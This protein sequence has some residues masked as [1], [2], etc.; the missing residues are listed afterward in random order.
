MRYLLQFFG[1]IIFVTALFS[2][3]SIHELKKNKYPL[4][5]SHFK[6][7]MPD[8]LQDFVKVYFQSKKIE[9]LSF[10][11]Y[12]NEYGNQLTALM[13]DWVNSGKV[14]NMTSSKAEE[15]KNSIK[16]VSNVLALKVYSDTS[17]QSLFLIDSIHWFVNLLPSKDTSPVFQRFIPRNNIKNNPFLVLKDFTDKVI[18]SKLLK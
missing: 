14:N 6:P 11:E 7:T 17:V 16:P 4:I 13:S 8:T 2:F 10:K 12:M 5:I 1:L 3:N 18:E 9:V 15:F